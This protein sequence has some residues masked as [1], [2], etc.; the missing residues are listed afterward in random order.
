MHKPE[1]LGLVR[2]QFNRRQ[3]VQF[4][5]AAGLAGL[6]PGLLGRAMAGDLGTLTYQLGWLKTVQYAGSFV[7][8]TKGFYKDVG[9]QSVA[10]DAGGPNIQALARVIQGSAFTTN[11]PPADVVSANAQ[12]ADLCIAAVQFPSGQFGI[13]SLAD[14]PIKSPADLIGKKVGVPAN[15]SLLWST[16]LKVNDIDEAAITVV[17]KQDDPSILV[18]GDVDALLAY[19]TEDVMALRA[20]GVDVNY[21][22]LADFGCVSP[23]GC[24]VIQRSRLKGDERA[25]LKAF[26]RAEILGWHYVFNHLDEAVDLTVNDYGKDLGLDPV[27]Q[28]KIAD[29]NK[30]LMLNGA[31]ATDGIFTLTDTLAEGVVGTLRASGVETSVAELFDLSALAEVYEE[32]PDLKTV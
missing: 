31:S 22:Y 3:F 8:Q 16:F 26:L 18:N 13:A 12:G 28:R 10:V 32:F 14:A 23:D 2:S 15:N 9:F 5:G 30:D 17:P 6:M 20:R 24:Y 4:A 29:A 27:A 21:F 7:A 11:T 25:R 19:Y 1:A